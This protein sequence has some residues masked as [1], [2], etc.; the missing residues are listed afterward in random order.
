[1]PPYVA[2]AL[3][4][5]IPKLVAWSLGAFIMFEL[6]TLNI[7]FRNACVLGFCGFPKTCSGLPSSCILPSAIKMTQSATSR[8]NANS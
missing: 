7:E 1:M 3:H 8:E 6:Y 5:L 4:D 2:F